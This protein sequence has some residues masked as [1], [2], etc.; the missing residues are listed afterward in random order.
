M[1]IAHVPRPGRLACLTVTLT[2][3]LAALAGMPAVAG[4]AIDLSAGD[5]KITDVKLS[6]QGSVS[7][8]FAFGALKTDAAL[9]A[10]AALLHVELGDRVVLRPLHGK[11]SVIAEAGQDR[12]TVI[13]TGPGGNPL[14]R[15]GGAF[16]TLGAHDPHWAQVAKYTRARLD[17]EISVA[18]TIVDVNGIAVTPGLTDAVV[19]KRTVFVDLPR[20]LRAAHRK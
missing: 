17:V 10:E 15:L 18:G 5:I 11:G 16:L 3:G 4:A 9:P 12:Y 20:A 14:F 13:P 19:Q 2:V 6:P 7:W 1:S 8:S